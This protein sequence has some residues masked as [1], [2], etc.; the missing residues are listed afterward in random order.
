MPNLNS[1]CVKN[2]TNSITHLK[3]PSGHLSV[4]G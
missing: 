3:R 4:I 2:G 1:N